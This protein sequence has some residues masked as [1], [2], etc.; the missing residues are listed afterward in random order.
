M[1]VVMAEW[2]V[3]VKASLSAV[4]K[5]GERVDALVGDLVFSMVGL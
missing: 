2:R 1:V 5:A 3:V 4:P